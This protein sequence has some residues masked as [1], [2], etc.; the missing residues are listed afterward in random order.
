MDY[1]YYVRKEKEEKVSY[2]NYPEIYTSLKHAEMIVDHMHYRLES[3]HKMQQRTRDK[4]AELRDYALEIVSLVNE[5][6]DEPDDPFD[7]YL[8]SSENINLSS[9]N[10]QYADSALAV[11]AQNEIIKATE[12]AYSPK[13]I[14]KN[15]Y[16]SANPLREHEGV[17]YQ[18]TGPVCELL[19][20]WIEVRFKSPSPSFHYTANKIPEWIDQIIAAYGIYVHRNLDTLF[21]NEFRRW[22]RDDVVGQDCIYPLPPLVIEENIEDEATIE[23][24]QLEDDIKPLIYSKRFYPSRLKSLSKSVGYCIDDGSI[25][26]L[27]R[28]EDS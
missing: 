9:P 13:S 12:Q 1:F 6:L 28:K 26:V 22:L 21:I 25:S 7:D 14:M 4:Y 23:I 15:V 3:E 24:V 20:D 18:E 2:D 17:C 16:N 27:H 19:A 5:L 11:P 10:I 8:C